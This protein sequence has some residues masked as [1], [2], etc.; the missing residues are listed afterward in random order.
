ML[1]AQPDDGG[2]SSFP[3]TNWTRIV[4]A[5]SEDPVKALAALEKLCSEYRPV[6]VK[7]FQRNDSVRDP[8][9]LAHSFIIYLLEKNLLLKFTLKGRPHQTGFRWFLAA[10]MKYFLRDVWDKDK[11]IVRGYGVEKVQLNDNDVDL[12]A[13]GDVDSQIDVEFAL[14]IHANV[15]RQLEVPD[16]AKPYILHNS[17]QKGWDEIARQAGKKSVTLRQE[18]SRLR[19]KHWE[20]FRDKVSRIVTPE[21]KVEDTRHLYELLFQHAPVV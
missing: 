3:E 16:Y 17:P 14:L 10:A 7:W 18:V 6:M 9:D 12:A 1:A 4:E 13:H 11:T 15:M 20:L 8:E 19:H 5:A 2:G 21:H